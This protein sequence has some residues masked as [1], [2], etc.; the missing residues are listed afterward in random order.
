[1]HISNFGL[2][3]LLITT[4]EIPPQPGCTK[5]PTLASTTFFAVVIHSNA[6]M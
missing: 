4:E 2:R 5:S 6:L 1:M 3:H